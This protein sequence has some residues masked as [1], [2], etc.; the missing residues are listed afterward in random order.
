MCGRVAAS[1]IHAARVTPFQVPAQVRL[2]VYSRL[3]LE[4]R[5]IGGHGQALDMACGDEGTGGGRFRLEVVHR[6]SA[7]RAAL[8]VKPVLT[9]H[10]RQMTRS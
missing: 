8:S 4:A 1:G 10:S 5:E 6:L 9:H 2:G 7:S 3:S